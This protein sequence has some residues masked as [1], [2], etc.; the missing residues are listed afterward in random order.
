MVL[1]F[2]SFGGRKHGSVRRVSLSPRG[3]LMAES[4][5]GRWCL[6]G[7]AEDELNIPA[8][9]VAFAFRDGEGGHLEGVLINRITEG[10]AP[11]PMCK[12]DGARLELRL[13]DQPIEY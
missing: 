6:I 10:E 3:E 4:I 2:V 11:L 5:A 12:F 9:H 13:P 1:A 8:H 7:E